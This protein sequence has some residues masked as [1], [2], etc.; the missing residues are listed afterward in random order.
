MTALVTLDEARARLRFDSGDSNGA[1][2]D[3]DLQIMINSASRSVLKYIASGDPDFLDSNG[4]VIE[5]SNG[6]VDVPDDVRDAVLLWVAIKYRNRDEDGSIDQDFGF[7][8]KQVVSI[9]YP[10]RLPTL[11]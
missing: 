6:P 2:D 3:G 1:P 11:G 7:P 10:Y 5:N 9:L 8:P 4:E